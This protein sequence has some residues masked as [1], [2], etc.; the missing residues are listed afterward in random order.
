MEPT[1]TSQFRPYQSLTSAT[2]FCRSHDKRFVLDEHPGNQAGYNDGSSLL[3]STSASGPRASTIAAMTPEVF[4]GMHPGSS[5]HPLDAWEVTL[6]PVMA[7]G[8]EGLVEMR[9]RNVVMAGGTPVDV[10][11][12]RWHPLHNREILGIANTVARACAGEVTHSGADST[13]SRFSARVLLEPGRCI[14]VTAAHTGGGALTVT[15]YAEEDGA[16]IRAGGTGS[17]WPHGPTI[18]ARIGS[19]EDIASDA[20]A[21]IETSN[22][23]I[24][25]AKETRLEPAQFVNA[26]SGLFLS[27]I[28]TA[29][30][31]ANARE[32][33]DVLA[34]KW[35]SRS[36]G[37]FD[38]WSAAVTISRWLDVERPGPNEDRVE[39]ALDEGGWVSR[40]KTT[41]WGVVAVAI[42]ENV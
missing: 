40:A 29:K 27:K 1:Y 41:A 12:S 20:V 14:V 34:R 9:G 22:A 17:R 32:T 10:V 21:W 33:L 38:A 11:G 31:Q 15:P 13:R 37:A 26:C 5:I 35:Q 24:S 16:L 8:A 39:L 2:M 23:A 3:S 6:S 19:A 30:R 18:E 7:M 25:R 4:A 28:R 36:N 42:E